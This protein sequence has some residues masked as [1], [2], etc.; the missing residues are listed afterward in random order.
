[1]DARPRK[2]RLKKKSPADRGEMTIANAAAPRSS[3][4]SRDSMH[5]SNPLFVLA[6]WLGL[7]ASPAA[8][9]AAP[10][11]YPNLAPGTITGRVIIQSTGEY[12]T[13]AE[14]RIAGRST[15]AVSGAGG[16]FSMSGLAPGETTIVATFT[17]YLPIEAKVMVVAGGT[18][19]KNLEF[20]STLN[21][22]GADNP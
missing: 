8:E 14:I 4:S 21:A 15:M 12:V 17:G 2:R 3:R 19:T 22:A 5:R 16:E 7:V 18:V 9:A 20:V 10:A 13:N 1:T 11:D 6:A